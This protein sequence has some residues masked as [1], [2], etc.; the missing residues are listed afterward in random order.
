VTITL[1]N[2]LLSDP[3]RLKG[4]DPV[5]SSC[6]P[7]VAV[8]LP[9]R[10]RLRLVVLD[11][12]GRAGGGVEA[13]CGVVQSGSSLPAAELADHLVVARLGSSRCSSVAI[14]DLV[15]DGTL[16]LQVRNAPPAMLLSAGRPA[17]LLP[18]GMPERV[19]PG[20]V[21]LLCS[22]SFFEDP[23]AVLGTVRQSPPGAASLAKLRRALKSEPHRGATASVAAGS[24]DL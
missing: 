12:A 7:G 22:A 14:A 3:V 2:D 9:M 5:V 21:L 1:P 6:A 8:A 20:E 16:D 13:V 4:W 10:D 11:L 18:G 19:N 23:P 17:R 24:L 15:P